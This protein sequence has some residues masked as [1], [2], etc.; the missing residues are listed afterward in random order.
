MAFLLLSRKG[1]SAVCVGQPFH[2]SQ[3]SKPQPL[4]DSAALRKSPS[5]A[6]EV[7]VR[8]FADVVAGRPP[9]SQEEIDAEAATFSSTAE[10]KTC[11]LMARFFAVRL[12]PLE[13]SGHSKLMLQ[14]LSRCL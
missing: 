1:K 2:R 11:R 5:R 7:L 14:T 13:F 6:L 10:D 4:A 3:H 9:R 8:N 12:H